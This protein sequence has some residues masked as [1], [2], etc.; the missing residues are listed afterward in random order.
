MS[1]A[2]ATAG[3][4]TSRQ[5]KR[6]MVKLT[7]LNLSW[8]SFDCFPCTEG[9]ITE[10]RRHSSHSEECWWLPASSKNVLH[11]YNLLCLL[12]PVSCLCAT[13]IHDMNCCA[14]IL[15]ELLNFRRGYDIQLTAHEYVCF[16]IFFFLYSTIYVWLFFVCCSQ[17]NWLKLLCFMWQNTKTIE[18]VGILTEEMKNTVILT[19]LLE[20][21]SNQLKFTKKLTHVK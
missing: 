14:S 6:A 7:S 5:I 18:F 19:K 13:D 2:A 10:R 11:I 20:W 1:T 9:V 8:R 17:G 3:T 16:M 4:A 15:W 12:E 21:Q